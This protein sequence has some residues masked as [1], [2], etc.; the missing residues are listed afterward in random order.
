MNPPLKITLWLAAWLTAA[1]LILHANSFS[2]VAGE[3]WNIDGLLSLLAG[4]IIGFL[5]AISWKNWIKP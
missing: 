3:P 2:H 5:L 1:A 4:E